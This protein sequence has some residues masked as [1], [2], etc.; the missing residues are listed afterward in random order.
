[1]TPLVLRLPWPPPELSPNVYV[2]H[3]A[4][5]RAKRDY[6]MECY[7]AARE[8]AGLR[9]GDAT[10]FGPDTLVTASVVFVVPDKR[11]RDLD[12]AM[13]SLKAGFDALVAAD[14][15]VDDDSEHLKLAAPE[16]RVQKGERYVEVTLR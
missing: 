10:Y 13:A 16:M 12:N 2:H 14:L 15:L 4:E 3:M 9:R 7:V 11:R 6:G 8:A 1:M 5:Y